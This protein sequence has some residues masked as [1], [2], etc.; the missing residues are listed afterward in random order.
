MMIIDMRSLLPKVAIW[1][2]Q[3]Y[4]LGFKGHIA[5]QKGV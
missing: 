3:V 1:G 2:R 4:I 5:I